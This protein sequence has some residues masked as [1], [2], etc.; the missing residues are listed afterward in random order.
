MKHPAFISE[1]QFEMMKTYYLTEAQIDP[2]NVRNAQPLYDR[3]VYFQKGLYSCNKTPEPS[4]PM[5]AGDYKY[6][7]AQ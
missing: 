1:S 4:P 3:Q 2:S 7:H 6:I 5:A